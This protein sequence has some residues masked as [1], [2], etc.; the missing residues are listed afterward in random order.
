MEFSREFQ[1]LLAGL[2]AGC[3]AVI[4]VAAYW[5]VAG[6]PDLLARPDNPRL[7]EAVVNTQRGAIYD[8]GGSILAESVTNDNQRFRSYPSPEA[9]S[10]VGYYSLQYGAGGAEAAYAPA[11]SGLDRLATPEAYL[12]EAILHRER[13]G[14]DIM[15][16]LDL[17][18]QRAMVE[19]LD[20][21]KGAAVLL[22]VPG[23]EVLGMVSLPMIDPNKLDVTYDE[24]LADP[25]NPFFNRATQARYQPGSA[26]QTVLAT[27]ALINAVPFEEVLEDADAPVTVGDVT[28]TCAER[29]PA[30]RLTLAEAYAYGC[31]APFARLY[32]TLGPE[33]VSET[34]DLYQLDEPLAL[35]GFA[36][37]EPL[38][39]S[40]LTS[41]DD[42]LGQGRITVTV[43]QMATIA[44]AV[45][46]DGNAPQPV[47]LRATRPPGA[48]EW[49]P[50][51]PS[52]VTLPVTTSENARR[53]A[54]LMIEV[55]YNGIAR[56]AARSDIRIGGHAAQAFAGESEISWF[57]G[58][59]QIGSGRGVAL[60]LALEDSA[61]PE[62]AAEIGGEIL[63]VG[64]ERR[65]AEV[66]SGSDSVPAR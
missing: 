32:E 3:A 33:E 6:A 58:F 18:I 55:T 37:P 20:G 24:L 34:F 45:L 54:A 47:L 56:R 27:A 7:F 41:L 61:D 4:I 12:E 5:A 30:S 9:A 17:D 38:E 49:T 13:V 15:L 40:G 62:L 25:D 26:I 39:L 65:S 43:M 1:R 16:T 23:G 28:L 50:V 44:A 60:A 10:A 52:S 48:P 63:K 57:I 53:I 36:L 8:R 59:A 19:A 29:P 2:L 22:S 46:N 51:A 64:Y 14:S 35:A 11:L 42:A 66:T 21:H 31:P